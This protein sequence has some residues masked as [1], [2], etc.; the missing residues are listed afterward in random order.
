MVQAGIGRIEARLVAGVPAVLGLLGLLGA[1]RAAIAQGWELGGGFAQVTNP[2]ADLF[3]PGNDCPPSKNWAGEGRIA[4]RFSRAVS[5]EGTGGY[6]WASNDYCVLAPEP[7]PDTGPYSTT[8]RYT[9]GG[10]PFVTTDARLAFEPSSPNG[11][12]WLRAF[13]GWGVMWSKEANYWLAGGGLVISG[14][15]TTI[16]EV[17]WNWFSIPYEETTDHYV[18][19]VLVSSET[20]SGN[21]SHGT[22]RLRAGFRWRP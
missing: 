7:I 5:L 6:H 10:F 21:T 2:P 12:M 14:R 18:D 15:V 1:P 22:F 13:G 19:G 11:S 17:E 3:D 16:F 20:A 8:S 9:P 4:L